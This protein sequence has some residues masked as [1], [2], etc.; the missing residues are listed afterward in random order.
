MVNNNLQFQQGPWRQVTP[1][2]QNQVNQQVRPSQP[3]NPQYNQ[4]NIQQQ[5]P[6]F[7]PQQFRAQYPPTLSRIMATATAICPLKYY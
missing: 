6:V 5:S 3:V 1:P 2:A 7:A 4:L